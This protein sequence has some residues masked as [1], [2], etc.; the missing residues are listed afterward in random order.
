[1]NIFTKR[2]A[3]KNDLAVWIE[4]ALS[5]ADRLDPLKPS[6][7]SILDEKSKYGVY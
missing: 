3:G 6:Q 4:W 2:E 5:H 7:P 1:M